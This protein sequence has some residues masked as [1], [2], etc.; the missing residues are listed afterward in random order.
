MIKRQPRRR[1][2]PSWP[3]LW[4]RRPLPTITFSPTPGVDLHLEDGEIP[5][6][7]KLMKLL[8]ARMKEQRTTKTAAA[9]GMEE[10]E[11]EASIVKRETQP[12]VIDV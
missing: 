1:K 10:E 11:Q 5:S 6:R 8:Q 4:P 9:A 12:L 2:T 7:V 3:R